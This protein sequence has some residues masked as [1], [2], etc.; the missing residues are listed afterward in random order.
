MVPSF[1]FLDFSSLASSLEEKKIVY[2]GPLTF[3]V[4]DAVEL[5]GY[6]L[7]IFYFLISGYDA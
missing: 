1:V 2:F 4:F 3:P 7:L 5:E 6:L